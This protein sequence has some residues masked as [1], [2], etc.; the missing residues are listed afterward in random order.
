MKKFSPGVAGIA[1]HLDLSA[2]RA[3]RVQPSERSFAPKIASHDARFF[4]NDLGQRALPVLTA[5][6]L[7]ETIR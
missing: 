6:N 4:R 3:E 5:Q 2:Q 1:P 7:A